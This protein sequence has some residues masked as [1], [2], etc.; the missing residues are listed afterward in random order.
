MPQDPNELDYVRAERDLYR[1]L[2]DV[3]SHED[4]SAFLDDA[5]GLIVGITGAQR[6][7]IELSA[8]GST[9]ADVWLAH[10]V[11]DAEIA[12]IRHQFSTGIIAEAL[13]TGKTI[14]TASAMGDPRFQMRNS[15]KAARIEAVLCAPIGEQSGFGV[16]YL[17]GRSS[18]GPFPA[19][20]VA[21]VEVFVSKI[22]PYAH[23]LL[24]QSLE[25]PTDHTLALRQR[26]AVE[27][28]VG[29][30]QT[31]A[32]CFQQLVVASSVDIPVLFTGE[33][34]SGKTAFAQALHASSA[35]KSKNFVEI[36]CA[37]LPET[38]LE[39]ELFGA[40]R[41]AHSTANRKI[42][43]KIAAA[44]GGTLFLDE[45]AEI[46]LASQA[47]LL[48]FL[49]SKQYFPLGSSKAVQADVRVIA[50]TN[51]SLEEAIAKRTFREDLFYRINVL[52]IRIPSLRTR[53]EDIALIA[54]RAAQAMSHQ[55][56]SSIRLRLSFAAKAALMHHDWP[57]NIRQL[58]ATIQRGAAFALSEEC[59]EI[60]VRH[61]FPQQQAPASSS[62]LTYSEALRQFQKQFLQDA[63]SNNQNNVSETARQLELSRSRLH[64]LL[65]AHGISRS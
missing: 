33:T 43:G 56:A 39:A 7:Y 65:R 51:V 26:L 30:S 49:Q 53:K 36:N 21:L 6:G 61:L 59:S 63:L 31:L 54:D 24:L 47:K 9:H 58:I 17:Q 1:R 44:E 20:D 35:R 16:L 8:S 62:H 64:E 4:I 23:K 40:E 41:G 15:V 5:L 25:H 18:T 38:L 34:G 13:R 10:G 28:L 14:S 42:V 22:A 11:E 32:A 29:C 37:A 3:G 2:L 57:G 12:S 45:L 46:P 27:S 60:D 55:S 52:A 48:Q 19:R 50:A